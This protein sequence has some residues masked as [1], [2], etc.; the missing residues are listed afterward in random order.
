MPTILSP[1][2][3][4]RNVPTDDRAAVPV[5]AALTKSKPTLSNH[6]WHASSKVHDRDRS[7]KYLCG[8]QPVSRV[9]VASMAWRS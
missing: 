9:R 6:I 7:R 1:S 8:N 2:N 3:L 5:L 4:L